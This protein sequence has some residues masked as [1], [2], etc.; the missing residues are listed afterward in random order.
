[1][2][3]L[4]VSLLELLVALA[5][6]TILMAILL[7]SVISIR[8]SSRA[9]TCKNNL[10]QIGLGISDFESANERLPVGNQLMEEILPFTEAEDFA[11]SIK[12]GDYSKL[13][14]D[15][16]VCPSD[17]LAT[18]EMLR[19][20]YRVNAGS[21]LDLN[22]GIWLVRANRGI[23]QADVIDGAS[24]TSFVAE[25]LVLQMRSP[26]DS[27]AYDPHR[28][29][30]RWHWLVNQHYGDGQETAFVEWCLS[31][32]SHNAPLSRT[33]EGWDGYGLNHLPYNHL[34]PPGERSFYNI[35]SRGIRVGQPI[36]ES[37]GLPP[38]SMHSNGIVNI[39]RVDGSVHSVSRGI[40][41]VTWHALGTRNGHEIGQSTSD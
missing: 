9:I 14:P 13:G 3:R 17:P 10:H 23:R 8:E 18:R 2:K 1:M 27:T 30:L 37:G 6:T 24:N 19:I 39:L 25:K 16:A 29:P 31:S 4:A 33:Y 26:T 35:T 38:S 41:L 36:T 21:N 22:N 40:D 34:L 5:I 15:F 7:P 20:S 32:A 12:A 11:A 28:Q